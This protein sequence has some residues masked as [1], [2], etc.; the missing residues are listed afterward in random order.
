MSCFLRHG[1][2]RRKRR[3]L[4]ATAREA[5][6]GRLPPARLSNW[7]TKARAPVVVGQSRGVRVA[8]RRPP[9]RGP[10]LGGGLVGRAHA[11]PGVRP[12]ERGVEGRHRGRRASPAS[13]SRSGRAR[14]EEGFPG[15]R[16][17]DVTPTASSPLAGN[18]PVAR[19][20][21][22]GARGEQSWLRTR[23]IGP[24]ARRWSLGHRDVEEAAPPGR[25]LTP[26][27]GQQAQRIERGV[28]DRSRCRRRSA[29]AG[30][31]DESAAKPVTHGSACRRR[32]DR[33]RADA[34]SADEKP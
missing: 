17:P 13:A 4:V 15:S 8:W 22:P 3:S 26:D 21:G 10:G 7:L 27:G 28:R 11:G 23:L 24:A 14:L 33:A 19:R 32:P 1:R 2:G 16:R 20:A 18:S 6:G 12:V 9:Q 25:A 30:P 31:G 29:A 34:P 5:E